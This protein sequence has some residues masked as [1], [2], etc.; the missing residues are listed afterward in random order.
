M[1]EA[2]A[3][4][5]DVPSTK[6]CSA[7]APPKFLRCADTVFL[8][9]NKN[10]VAAEPTYEAVLSFAKVMQ[11]NPVKVPQTAD[12]RHDLNAMAAATNGSTGLVYICNPNN[13]TGTIV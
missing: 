3:K 4:Y 1:T 11:A 10:V 2:I 6:C 7:A 13:P 8:G 5:H 9:P 12:H